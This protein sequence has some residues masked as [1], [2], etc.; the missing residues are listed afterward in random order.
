MS[1]FGASSVY[2]SAKVNTT[3]LNH[4]AELVERGALRTQIGGEYPLE[5]AREAFVFFERGHPKGKIILGIK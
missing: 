2:V 4:L 1:K 3:S 5:R